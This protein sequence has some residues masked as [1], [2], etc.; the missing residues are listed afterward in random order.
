MEAITHILM[1][2]II[3]IEVGI[4]AGLIM[5]AK[6]WLFKQANPIVMIGN[7]VVDLTTVRIIRKTKNTESFTIYF[8]DGT[9]IEYTT[10]DSEAANTWIKELNTRLSELYN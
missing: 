7:S 9:H 2:F 5:K 4:I 3:A 1:G 10:V 8:D 6:K